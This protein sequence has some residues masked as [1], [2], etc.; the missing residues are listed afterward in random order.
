MSILKFLGILFLVLTVFNLLIVVHEWGHFL[1][2]RWR[3]LRIDRFQI[4]F[5]KPIWKKTYNGVQYGLGSVPFGGF[6]ALPQM[7]PMEAIEGRNREEGEPESEE[8]A[9]ETQEPLPPISPLDKIIVAFAGPL[10]S[11]LLAVFFALIIWA[12]GKPV[13]DAAMAREVG[14]V[15]TDSPAAKGGILPGDTIL[16][17]DGK[18][19]ETIHG[20]VNSMDWYIISAEKSDLEFTIQRSGEELKK[21]VSIPS[22]K[23]PEEKAEDA[24]RK[25][26]EVARDFVFKRPPLP[27]VGIFGRETPRVG[28]VKPN[29]PAEEAG[30]EKADLI[31]G[32]DGQEVRHLIQVSDAIE[33]KA[34]GAPVEISIKRGNA[35]KTVSVVPRRPEKDTRP[36]EFRR[37]A[38]GLVWDTFG[39]GELK[40]I[41]PV[42]QIG[43]SLAMIR[44][45]LGAIFSPKTKVGATHL[46]S[47]VGIMRVYYR[48]FEHPDGWRL[49]LWFSVILN[50]NLAVLNMLPF[51]VLDGGHIVMAAIESIRRKPVNLKILEVVQTAAVICL[52]T[53]M[54]VLVL[55]DVGDL[56]AGGPSAVVEFLPK[57]SATPAV[58]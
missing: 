54:G 56:T 5:G 36:E 31:V 2:A 48:L 18:P 43:D 30:I 12:V 17:V 9:P 47:A 41:D 32:V 10:F 1:A 15:A 7:A 33:K 13:P 8:D 22:G 6:V 49:V 27:D 26:W 16:E 57:D 21:T 24:K 29:S 51:P 39:K 14:Y 58:P 40:R 44:N 3:G 34:E 42:T 37:P 25:W 11:F 35:E 28:D 45:T 4:W 19:V 52:L 53:L 46:S 20:M 55:K 50:V 38:I 23:T